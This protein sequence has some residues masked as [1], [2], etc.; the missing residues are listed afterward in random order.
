METQLGKQTEFINRL[1]PIFIQFLMIFLL[2][3]TIVK[4]VT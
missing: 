3:A 2:Y 4:I 1:D